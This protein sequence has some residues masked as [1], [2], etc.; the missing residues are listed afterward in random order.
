MIEGQ[1]HFEIDAQPRPAPDD[2]PA[3]KRPTIVVHNVTEGGGPDTVTPG[4]EGVS[5]DFDPRQYRV[6]DEADD[7]ARRIRIVPRRAT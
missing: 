1:A 3:Q 7:K 6:L 2:P 4:S 5:I